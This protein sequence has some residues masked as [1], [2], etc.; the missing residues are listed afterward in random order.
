MEVRLSAR[1][2]KI[3]QCWQHIPEYYSGVQVIDT[4]VMPEHFHGLL[5]LSAAPN[6]ETLEKVVRSFKLGCNKIY[7]A[8]YH[9]EKTALFPHAILIRL[10][11][12]KQGVPNHLARPVS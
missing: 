3:L 4:Q 9:Q 6:D 12:S 5:H 10:F 11:I 2:E 8:Q 1:G 7:G